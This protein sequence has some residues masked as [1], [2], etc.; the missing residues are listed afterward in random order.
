MVHEIPKPAGDGYP[1]WVQ[2]TGAHDAYQMGDRVIFDGS[3]YESTINANTWSPADYPA[4][5]KKIE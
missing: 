2:P 5:W 4:G 1:E 3:V